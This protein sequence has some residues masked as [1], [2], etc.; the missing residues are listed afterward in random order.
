MSEVLKTRDRLR[1]QMLR[2]RYLNLR[3][4]EPRQ[5]LAVRS[6]SEVAAMLGISRQRVQQLERMAMYKVRLGLL[7]ALAETNAELRRELFCGFTDTP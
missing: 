1:H 5:D 2:T 7:G 3:V 6:Q 4:S